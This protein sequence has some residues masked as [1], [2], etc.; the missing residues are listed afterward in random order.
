MKR[1]LTLI[2]LLVAIILTTIVA[3]IALE[4]VNGEHENY[5]VTRE[6]IRLQSDAR[7]AVRIMEEETKNAGYRIK[8]T[9]N[10]GV[11][12]YSQCDEVLYANGSSLA[13]PA[14][15][16]L[17]FHFFEGFKPFNCGTADL[18]TVAYRLNGTR[19]E[20]KASQGGATSFAQESWVPFLENVNE[21]KVYYGI[22]GD[23]EE[24]ITSA[25]LTTTNPSTLFNTQNASIA[26]D[27]TGSDRPWTITGWNTTA[28]SVFLKK[29]L[30][31]DAQSTYRVSFRTYANSSFKDETNGYARTGVNALIASL[32][33]TTGTATPSTITF[34]PGVDGAARKIQYDIS[35]NET[36]AYQF[37]FYTAMT[38]TVSAPSLNISNLSITRLRSGEY[39][40]WIDESTTPAVSLK[41][42]GA[43]KI[44]I[45][46][47]GKKN[48][49]LNL[50]RIIPVV[51][52]VKK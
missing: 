29:N 27:Q 36:G 35:V 22:L 28:G 31:L 23:D 41:K 48:E 49:D 14:I 21:F 19:L 7:E 33:P 50:E 43:I 37:G 52:N 25:D 44:Q 6:K 30:N 18:W 40:E 2:E 42:I 45:K 17:E 20:R 32:K 9:I 1:G 39:R 46:A 3:F 15:G 5:T 24:L 38:G 16:M 13:S 51:N 4:F 12:T 10:N 26:V 34:E 8:T 11:L 47:K